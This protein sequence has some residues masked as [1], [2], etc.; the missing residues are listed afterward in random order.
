MLGVWVLAGLEA[1]D[2]EFNVAVL[3]FF[4]VSFFVFCFSFVL[5]SLLFTYCILRGAFVL[6]YAF[7]YYLSKK[8]KKSILVHCSGSW[9]FILVEV[10]KLLDISS[11]L[12]RKM[13][14]Q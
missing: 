1:R 4:G 3:G 14:V 11:P 12:K 9:E 7:V 13:S 5:V 6:F 10:G 8:K 2:W